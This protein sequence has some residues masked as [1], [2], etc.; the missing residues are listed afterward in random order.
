VNKLKASDLVKDE[1]EITKDDLT[2]I[3]ELIDVLYNGAM[4]GNMSAVEEFVRLS[5]YVDDRFENAKKKEPPPT[6]GIIKVMGGD[7]F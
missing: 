3:K 6:D 5:K 7:S 1:S 4:S 2:K